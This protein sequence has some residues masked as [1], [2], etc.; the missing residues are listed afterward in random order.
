MRGLQKC[1][2]LLPLTL[3]LARGGHLPAQ[4]VLDNPAFDHFYN[5][6]YDQALAGFITE[7]KKSPDSPDVQNH[8]AQTILFR[9]MFRAGMLQSQMLTSSNSFLKMPKMQMSGGDCEQFSNAIARAIELAQARL[10]K[11]PKDSGALYALGVSYGLRGNYNFAVR[12]A[13]LDALHD[14]SAA[15]KFHNRVTRFDPD[16]VDAELT[17]GVYEYIVGSLPLGWRMLGFVG[18]FQGSRARGIAM[19]NRVA[20]EGSTNRID[21][22]V[23]LAAIYRREHRSSDAIDVLKPLIPLLPRNYLLRLELAEMYGDLADHDAALAVLDQL[24]QL[25]RSH[26]PGYETLTTDLIHEVRERILMDIERAS[27]SA[28]G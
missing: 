6:E 20:T 21:A 4:N 18:G 2:V 17:Q 13:Y 28:G 11:N 19:L 3:V 23:F 12:K 7:A 5:L 15:R 25:R 14:M 1:V 16:M 10:E 27:T 8:I 26:T 22:I 24:E 9:E